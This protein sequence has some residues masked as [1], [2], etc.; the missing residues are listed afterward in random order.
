MPGGHGHG[1]GGRGGGRGAASRGEVDNNKFYELLGVSK[2]ADASEIKKAYRKAALQH[3]PDR[4]GDA[5]RFKEISK[6]H[7]ILS[8][9]EKRALYDEGGEEAL[10]GGG[11][12]GGPAGMDIFD[13]FGGGFGGGAR[14]GKK[15]SEDV[16]FPLKSSTVHT[17]EP[18]IGVAS[19]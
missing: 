19:S 6:A 17:L 14:R 1:H 8:D 4:G 5:E 11:G 13:L 18:V 9:P 10:E 2:E 3:H 15:R 7:E 16:I 12:G